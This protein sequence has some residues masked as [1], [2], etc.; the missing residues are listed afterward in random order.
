MSDDKVRETWTYCGIRL[1]QGRKRLHAWQD[2]SGELLYFGKLVGH[3]IGGRYEVMAN[4][5]PDGTFQTVSLAPRYAGSQC[6]DSE[7]VAQ[8]QT[9]SRL[10]VVK[11][12]RD[13]A[14]RKAKAE[15]DAFEQAVQPLRDLRAKSCRTWAERVAFLSMVVESLGQ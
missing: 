4:R 1:S 8:W 13:R 15:R 10:A 14:E 2:A 6:D 7:Q 5:A 12:A 9:E 3:A 11:L